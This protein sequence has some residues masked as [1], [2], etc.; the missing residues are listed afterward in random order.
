MCRLDDSGSRSV[1]LLLLGF[2]VG[3]AEAGGLGGWAFWC[4]ALWHRACMSGSLEG[5][6]GH[7]A[8]VLKGEVVFSVV[9]QKTRF[10]R[11]SSSILA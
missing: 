8:E 11:S 2:A 5:E 6:S 3:G 10:A 7:W 4:G 1:G 9:T